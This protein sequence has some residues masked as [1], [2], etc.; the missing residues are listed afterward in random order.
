[1]RD[2]ELRS[3]EGFYQN[4]GGERGSCPIR[5][6]EG[7]FRFV[8]RRRGF[9]DGGGD[10]GGGGGGGDG[11]SLARSAQSNSFATERRTSSSSLATRNRRP[12]LDAIIMSYIMIGILMILTSI[13]RGC[14]FC[15]RQQ[16]QQLQQRSQPQPQPQQQQFYRTIGSPFGADRPTRVQEFNR[17]GVLHPEYQIP[18]TIKPGNVSQ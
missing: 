2:R 9:P 18:A 16:L 15:A 12:S 10:G 6:R 7:L 3:R 8:G 11:S 14:P 1:M 17:T 5:N 4:T 13:V